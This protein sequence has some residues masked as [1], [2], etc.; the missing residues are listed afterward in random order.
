[1][2]ITL[3]WEA[4]EGVNLQPNMTDRHFFRLSSSGK[5]SATSAYAAIF[6]GYLQWE[7]FHR[8]WKTWAPPKCIFFICLVIHNRDIGSIG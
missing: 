5:Y 7:A 6:Q 8:V 1:M 2:E 3:I 4:F